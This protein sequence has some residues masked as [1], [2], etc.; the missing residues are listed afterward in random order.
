M[1]KVSNAA[2]D[3][4]NVEEISSAGPTLAFCKDQ[5]L[6]FNHQTCFTD[7]LLTPALSP[8]DESNEVGELLIGKDVIICLNVNGMFD[9][10][11]DTWQE[12]TDLAKDNDWYLECKVVDVRPGQMQVRRP[13]SELEWIPFKHIDSIELDSEDPSE[14]FPTEAIQVRE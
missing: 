3:E 4:F 2:D 13:N 1:I 14:P 9:G 8:E 7:K 12:I 11:V 5:P 10:Y 6:I